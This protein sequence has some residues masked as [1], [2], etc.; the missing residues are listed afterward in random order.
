MNPR[1]ALVLVGLLAFST[2]VEGQATAADSTAEAALVELT[3]GRIASRTMTAYPTRDGVLLPM[4]DVFD[5]SEVRYQTGELGRVEITL[6][7]GNRQVELD[8]VARTLKI[9]GD[10]VPL[11]PTQIMVREDGIYLSDK[12]LGYLLG[13][14][15][16]A[17]WPELEV[18]VADPSNLPITRRMARAAA[19]AQIFG[20]RAE[21]P[22]LMLG[23]Q[24]GSV[25][26]AV[27]DYS[28]LTPLTTVNGKYPGV[29]F[30]TGLGLDVGGG[31]LQVGVA[32]AADQGSPNAVRVDASWSGVWRDQKW[33]TQLRLGDGVSTGPRPQSVRGFS[34]SNSPYLRPAGFG[35]TTF[36][37]Q[38][39]PGWEIQAFRG[40][41]LIGLDSA[42]ALGQF[43]MDVPV[44][45]G[46]NAVDFV[47]YG[48]FGEVR[49]FNRN[50]RVT[51]ALLP[52]NRFEYGVS[53]GACRTSECD[54]SGNLDLR[55]GITRRWTVGGGVEQF[56]RSN[57]P[58]LFH[59]YAVVSGSF[60]NALSAQLQAMAGAVVQGALSL[61]PS[62]DLRVT[63]EYNHFATGTVNPI[64]TP[65]GRLN[66]FTIDGFARPVHT[67]SVFLTYGFDRIESVTGNSVSGRLG[68][69]VM[70]GSSQLMPTIRVQTNQLTGSPALT[71]TFLGMNAILMPQ[72]AL[73]P[74]LGKVTG[75]AF[76]EAEAGTGWSTVAGYLSRPVIPGLRAEVGA[77]WNRGNGTAFTFTLS[78]EL[79]T[80]R[81]T[82]SVAANPAGT[83]ASQYVQGSM[84]Y[85][86]D[87]R[88]VGFSWA[89]GSTR[90]G[91]AGRVFLDQ[92]G[93]GVW[94]QGEPLLAGV[95]V[96]AG[97]HQVA[98]DSSGRY[99]IWDLE[100]YEPVDVEVDSLSL[101]SPLWA[102]TFGLVSV[103][104]GPNS[105]RNLDLAI[106][107]GGTID[108]RVLRETIEGMKGMG[109]VPL[110]LTDLKTGRTR[111]LTTF[112]DGAFYAIGIKPGDYQLTV[113]P[114]ILTR[115]S[116]A[117]QPI[118]LN[119][120][121]VMDGASVT[122]L[123]IQL[124][125]IPAPKP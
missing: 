86:P 75:R 77:G 4:A 83:S 100:P 64:L 96:R 26:G 35:S 118:R 36:T 46:E 19:R 57:D 56:W 73:G 90:A 82:T 41:R 88:R 62:S 69:S 93:N 89:P 49:E 98:T 21:E 72:P 31:S 38:L 9:K 2:R 112:S 111:S 80:V 123:D 28:L 54:A 113:S 92:N 99:L 67:G 122:G 6:Q 48:P 66:Q 55:Y 74:V 32:T 76:I 65:L 33:L 15:F 45:Y 105:F 51:Q 114:Q 81:G 42:N 44:Q 120:P 87:S 47:A 3:L 106:A 79:P 8:P 70:A 101:P 11:T 60:T 50:Y 91:V 10:E 29:V 52:R 110:V 104:P 116:M 124:T 40:G 61:E 18:V 22:D 23:L 20:N 71:S 24:R 27:L 102:P 37:G 109:G 108:G 53:L 117:A 68:A 34:A 121:A 43:S 84:L 39:G 1:A 94:D 16:H 5:L 95:K 78:T 58:N 7:P 12:V 103:E 107:P 125:S 13:V 25:D 97:I 115:L 59:P 14:E 85:D 119:M 30:S 63:A 17:D